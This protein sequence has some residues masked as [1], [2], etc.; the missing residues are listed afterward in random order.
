MKTNTIVRIVAFVIMLFAAVLQII[1]WVK[2]DEAIEMSTDLQDN[3][4]GT[5]LNLTYVVLFVTA[6]LAVVLSVLGVF[7]DAKAAKKALIGL[8]G[9]VLVFVLSYLFS[10]GADHSMYVVEGEAAT[11]A[12]SRQVGTGL[13]AFYVLGGA[14]VLSILYV[15]VSRIFNR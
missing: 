1:V 11:E 9:M 2:G 12:T 4:L 5:Y 10:N 13:I 15:E 14:A 3:L 7:K 6:A 8:G